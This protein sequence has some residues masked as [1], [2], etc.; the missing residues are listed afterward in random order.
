[1]KKHF[2]IVFPNMP[3]VSLLLYTY[4]TGMRRFVSLKEGKD[5]LI[6]ALLRGDMVMLDEK[7]GLDEIGAIITVVDKDEWARV[8]AEEFA[9]REVQS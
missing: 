7:S 4:A 6:G 8:A 2:S 5:I 3:G 1:M 9:A